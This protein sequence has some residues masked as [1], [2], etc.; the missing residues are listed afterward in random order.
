MGATAYWNQ[1]FKIC[2]IPFVSCTSTAGAVSLAKQALSFLAG[3]PLWREL[4]ISPSLAGSNLEICKV[5]KGS[6]CCRAQRHRVPLNLGSKSFLWK[7]TGRCN[8]KS[9][10]SRGN[11]WVFSLAG[12]FARCRA[13]HAASV[14]TEWLLRFF[15]VIHG[16]DYSGSYALRRTCRPAGAFVSCFSA[17][18]HSNGATPKQGARALAQTLL[19]SAS[20]VRTWQ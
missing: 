18:Q 15:Q 7:F 11:S 12:T 6:R 20:P 17:A 10:V 1:S 8:K 9:T 2:L 13:L 5:V 19:S 14:N 3:S 16:G 4:K